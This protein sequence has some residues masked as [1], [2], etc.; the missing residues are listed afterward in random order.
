MEIALNIIRW[1]VVWQ[2]EGQ[3]KPWP[4]AEI[5]SN[6]CID[7]STV[8][9]TLRL[10]KE[11]GQVSPKQ[12]PKERAFRKLTS[13]AQAFILG[14]VIDNPGIYLHKIQTELKDVFDIVIRH[15]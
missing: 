2:H 13:R 3:Q 15:L 12:Y 4:V 11:T 14:L 9:R 1:R 7:K 8:Y 10:F 6:L 5:A